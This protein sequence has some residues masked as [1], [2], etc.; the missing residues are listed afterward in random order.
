MTLIWVRLTPTRK[1]LI[2]CHLHHDADDFQETCKRCV[3]ETGGLETPGEVC[4]TWLFWPGPSTS[5]LPH[6]LKHCLN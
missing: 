2:V 4:G 3:R 6:C 5:F 1:F